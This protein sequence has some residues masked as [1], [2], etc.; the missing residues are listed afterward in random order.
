M[1][2]KEICL[3][4]LNY[5]DLSENEIICNTPE[6]MESLC[7]FIV[8]N[9]YLEVIQFINSNFFSDLIDKVKDNFSK[10]GQFKEIINKLHKHTTENNRSFKFIVNE[11]N[12]SV[13][14]KIK[15]FNFFFEYKHF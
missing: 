3:D 5:L 4:N 6:K 2:I 10:S 8:K 13:I 11:G 9:R 12:E 1:N 14:K 7:N 15:E